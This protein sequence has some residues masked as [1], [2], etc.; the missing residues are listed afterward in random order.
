MVRR[1][2]EILAPNLLLPTWWKWFGLVN[3][4]SIFW[5]CLTRV[6]MKSLRRLHKRMRTNVSLLM[7]VRTVEELRGKKTSFT[8]FSFQS[9]V[10]GRRPESFHLQTEFVSGTQRLG[11]SNHRLVQWGGAFQQGPG[12][13][14]SYLLLHSHW[15]IVWRC[16]PFN[17]AIRL[18]ITLKWLGQTQWRY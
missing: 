14:I 7:I 5:L 1:E 6:G 4:I 3:V 9:Q 15:C 16:H 12:C 10:W 8:F 2:E 17:S 11:K 13:L 18:D